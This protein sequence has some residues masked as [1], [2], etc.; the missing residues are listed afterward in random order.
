MRSLVALARP[1]GWVLVTT[2]NQLSWLSLLCLVVKNRFA[3]FQDVHYPAHLT[4]L[5]EVDLRRLAREASLRDVSR[6]IQRLR[7]H[8]AHGSHVSARAQR[9]LSAAFLR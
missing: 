7:P 5:L 2:P 1:G 3:A 6:E 8:S 4:A 9:G